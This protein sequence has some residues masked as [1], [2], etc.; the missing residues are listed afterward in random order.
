MREFTALMG[1]LN[2]A[3]EANDPAV[4]VKAHEKGHL[5]VIHDYFAAVAINDFTK[6][7][8]CMTEDVTFEMY[9]PAR[10]P[11]NRKATGKQ[12]VLAT[13]HENYAMVVDQAPRM[14]TMVAQG[15]LV[16][17]TLTETGTFKATGESYACKGLIQLRMRG[18][19]IASAL[20]IV[21]DVDPR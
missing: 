21:A 16:A 5:P 1:A 18:G 7:A 19:L 2:T 11:F 15:D 12:D 14:E 9:A 3:F 20:I 13:A 17:M 4:A 8:C 10:Y 6:V